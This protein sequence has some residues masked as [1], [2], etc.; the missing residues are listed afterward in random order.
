[1][2]KQS[3]VCSHLNKKRS[4][5][6]K[7]R[8]MNEWLCGGNGILGQPVLPGGYEVSHVNWRGIAKG[9]GGEQE[10]SL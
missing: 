8:Q 7:W 1:M 10:K 9:K 3:F 4:V 2:W 6:R 5:P